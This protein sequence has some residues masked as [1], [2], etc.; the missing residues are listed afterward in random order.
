MTPAGSAERRAWSAERG[1]WRGM[2]VQCGA[3]SR[4]K[5][6]VLG[7]PGDEKGGGCRLGSWETE[8]RPLVMS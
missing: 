3:W 1:A 7:R 6:S 5:V 4:N 8:V 2:V